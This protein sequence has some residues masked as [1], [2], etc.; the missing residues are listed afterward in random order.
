MKPNPTPSQDSPAQASPPVFLLTRLIQ[1]SQTQPDF[2]CATLLDQTGGI[3]SILT[4]Q[5]W[6]KKAETL[7]TILTAQGVQKG[8]RVLVCLP[9]SEE[10]LIAFVGLWWIGA[11]P[12]PLPEISRTQKGSLTERL[13]HVLADCHPRAIVIPA[14][15]RDLLL[16]QTQLHSAQ[17]RIWEWPELWPSDETLLKPSPILPPSEHSPEQIA[18]IQ[19]TS[20]STG[21]PKG[22]VVTHGALYAN[23]MAMGQ[24]SEMG[25]HDD[26]GLTWMP[27]YHDMGLVGG[28]ML[29]TYFQIPMYLWPTPYFTANPKLWLG[30]ISRYK[31][32]LSTSPNFIYNFCA[33][34]LKPTEIPDLDLSSWRLAFNGAEPIDLETLQL[35]QKKFGPYGFSEK[36]FYPVYGMAEATL[37]ITF[38]PAGS[39]IRSEELDGKTYVSVGHC[40]TGHQLVIRGMSTHAPLAERE[41][42]EICFSGPSVCPGYYDKP[43]LKQ[44]TQE[45]RTGDLGFVSGQDLYVVDR[46][47]DL[48]LIGGTNYYPSD[49]E[50][51]VSQI[52]G[53]QPGRCIAFGLPDSQAGTSVLVLVA[54]ITRH[55]EEEKLKTEIRSRLFAS[56]GI[57]PRDIVLSKRRMIP[58]T[59]SGKIMRRRCQEL[60]IKGELLAQGSAPLPHTPS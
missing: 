11:V 41:V 26:R 20:G 13:R 43:S 35:F 46:I 7:G 39:L 58:L 54:E 31:I 8:D 12:V 2:A 49:L 17:P 25:R 44:A 15:T 48:I 29:L 55:A 28:V 24:V 5:T 40:L 30:I 42:G 19:Y 32:T 34:K 51:E 27:L 4:A 16:E 60:Y 21:N 37:A 47:K 22:V 33:R 6:V 3:A 50:K 45:L 9:T 53:I 38:P 10:F 14:H 1:L 59:S 18:F 56:H 36:T 52:E 57:A 23:C